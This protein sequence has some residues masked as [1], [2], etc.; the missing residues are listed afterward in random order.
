MLNYDEATVAPAVGAPFER[1]VMRLVPERAD[2]DEPDEPVCQHCHGDGMDPMCDY[3]LPCP[4]CQ[5][6]HRPCR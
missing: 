6:E 3:L 2:Y 5:G 4:A 1:R